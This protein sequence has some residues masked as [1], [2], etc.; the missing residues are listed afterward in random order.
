M[1]DG[2]PAIQSKTII[3]NVL[4]LIIALATALISP[5]LAALGIPPEAARVA[6]V[7]LALANVVNLWLRTQT[8]EPL[9]GT[10]AAKRVRA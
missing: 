7:V 8:S 4:S 9:V 10:A 6:G 5:D 1:N 2:K 3:I